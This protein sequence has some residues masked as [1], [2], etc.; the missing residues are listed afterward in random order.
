MYERR[1]GTKEKIEQSKKEGVRMQMYPGVLTTCI[2]HR[3]DRALYQG[4]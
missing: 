1:L 2:K 3:T 4:T